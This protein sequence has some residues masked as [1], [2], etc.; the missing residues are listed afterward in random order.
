M[1]GLAA[2]LAT[3]CRSA[4]AVAKAARVTSIAV[5]VVL[6]GA[7]TA[8]PSR[9][10]EVMSAGGIVFPETAHLKKVEG[11]VRVE[12]DVSSRML[13]WPSRPRR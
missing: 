4:P 8:S 3:M 7:C 12:Y 6:L 5:A 1:N 10:P 11:Y 13:P 9:P 2:L